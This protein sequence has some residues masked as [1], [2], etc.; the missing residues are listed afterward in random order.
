MATP[1]TSA[2]Q[3]G[4]IHSS[5]VYDDDSLSS[6]WTDAPVTAVYGL[7]Y[8]FKVSGY[9]TNLLR[10]IEYRGRIFFQS[11]AD[12]VSS[13]TVGMNRKSDIFLRRLTMSVTIIPLRSA[14]SSHR[15]SK[16]IIFNS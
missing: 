9:I 14:V 3:E 16:V 1:R 10:R 5:Y 2:W 11:Q 12:Q 8:S 6:A 13:L 7:G 15:C 4:A